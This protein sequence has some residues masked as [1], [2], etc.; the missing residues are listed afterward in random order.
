MYDAVA[1]L[2]PYRGALV[3]MLSRADSKDEAERALS[4]WQR[5]IAEDDSLSDIWYRANLLASMAGQLFVRSI[6]V[7]QRRRS[8]AAPPPP[9]TF[10][11]LP[12]DE[13]IR[14]FLARAPVTP[15]QFA[16][17]SDMERFRSFTISRITSERV[18]ER[19]QNLLAQA[20]QPDGVG[21][22]E[23]V[24]LVADDAIN[25]GISP[26]G[27]GYLENV[28]R[29]NTAVSYNAGRYEAQKDPDVVEATGY[30]QYLTVDDDRVRDEH[31]D[32]H[33]KTW[34]IGD[35][36]AERV[37]PPSG[38][39]CRCAMAVIDREDV[40]ESNLQRQVFV[41]EAITEGFSGPPTQIIENEANA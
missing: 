16:A 3:D 26:M 10:V 34:T 41:D 39:Q 13:A 35:A 4:D 20:F 31:A 32:L 2:E 1:V 30:W 22:R 17:M 12:F 37:Y 40:E 24:R 14:S 21:L 28:F 15:E 25:I 29:T 7:K 8:L 19:A 11:N 36:D 33:G 18:R 27:H 23:F 5:A 6:E 38:F 9:D